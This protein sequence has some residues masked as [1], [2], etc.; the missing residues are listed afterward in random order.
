MI[1]NGTIGIIFMTTPL[2]LGMHL[3]AFLCGIGSL[4]VALGVKFTPFEWTDKFPR[5]EEKQTEDSFTAKLEARLNKAHSS[6]L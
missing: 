4:L 2:T 1:G 6:V 5:L 3:T